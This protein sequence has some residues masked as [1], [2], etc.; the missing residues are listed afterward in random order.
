MDT[1]RAEKIAYLEKT[2]KNKDSDLTSLAKDKKLLVDKQQAL[3]DKTED[4]TCQEKRRLQVIEEEDL[5]DMRKREET[6]AM[7]FALWSTRKR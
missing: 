6:L 2:T 4:L 5:P 7:E 3:L 1:A